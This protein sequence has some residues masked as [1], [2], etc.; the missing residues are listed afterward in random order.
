MRPDRYLEDRTALAAVSAW[1]ISRPT[2]LAF[3]ASL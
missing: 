2:G 3:W 1:R